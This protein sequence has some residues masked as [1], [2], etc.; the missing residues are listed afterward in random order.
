MYYIV[1][2][3]RFKSQPNTKYLLNLLCAKPHGGMQVMGDKAEVL[4]KLRVK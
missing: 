1:W 4:S 3:Q 2:H